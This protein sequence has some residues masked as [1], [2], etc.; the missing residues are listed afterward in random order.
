MHLQKLAAGLGTAVVLVAFAAG[1]FAFMGTGLLAQENFAGQVDGPVALDAPTLTVAQVNAWQ[2]EVAHSES[3]SD[4]PTTSEAVV[5]D[6]FTYTG[7]RRTRIGR[8][9]ASIRF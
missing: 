6:D 7:I 5:L 9:T 1:A 3:G 2:K 8:A 4:V